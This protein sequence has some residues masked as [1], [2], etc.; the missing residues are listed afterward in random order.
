MA[1]NAMSHL[2][3]VRAK[4]GVREENLFHLDV[5]VGVC[6]HEYSKED[7]VKQ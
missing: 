3:S 6:S 5:E 2:R 1:V 7:T 4:K